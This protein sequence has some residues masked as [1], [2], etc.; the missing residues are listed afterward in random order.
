MARSTFPS[1]TGTSKGRSSLSL[2]RGR[3]VNT[4]PPDISPASKRHPEV[5]RKALKGGQYGHALDLSSTNHSAVSLTERQI[6]HYGQCSVCWNIEEKTGL[7][8]ATMLM[9]LYGCHSGD[10]GINPPPVRSVALSTLAP[11]PESREAKKAT[12]AAPL[13]PVTPTLK[14]SPP[15]DP[16]PPEPIE[17][18]PK[19]KENTTEEPDRDGETDDK[20]RS[21]T[22]PQQPE[23]TDASPA[24]VE[25]IHQ[26]DVITTQLLDTL[27]QADIMSPHIRPG[28]P[29]VSEGQRL[30]RNPWGEGAHRALNV[31]T[32]WP[33][34]D[35]SA[36]SLRAALSL[37]VNGAVT[38]PVTLP[39]NAALRFS[40]A[41]GTWTRN[42][43]PVNV[44]VLV[45]ENGT[46]RSVWSDQKEG[47][48]IYRL[49]Q[50][51]PVEISLSDTL[52]PVSIQVKVH[53]TVGAHRYQ[54]VAFIAEPVIVTR[55]IDT[56]SRLA[57]KKQTGLALAD[58]VLLITV[59][60]QRF[61]SL[62]T[63]LSEQQST[64]AL[65]SANALATSGASFTNAFSVS[66]DERSSTFGLLSSQTP[67]Y[68]GFFHTRW[69]YPKSQVQEFYRKSSTMLP[70][71]LRKHGYRTIGIGHTTHLTGTLNRSLD[72][73]FDSLLDYRRHKDADIQAFT[74]QALHWIRDHVS[75][76]W[77]MMLHYPAPP[78]SPSWKSE[79]GGQAAPLKASKI[80]EAYQK[81]L[82]GIDNQIKRVMDELDTLNLSNKTVVVLTGTHGRI[83]NSEH[84]CWNYNAELPCIYSAGLTLY[85]E[86]MHVPLIIRAPDR[87]SRQ[88]IVS[89]SVSHLDVAPTILG[90]IGAAP[91]ANQLG[92]D[93]STSLAKQEPIAPVPILL[94]GRRSHGCRWNGYKYIEHGNREVMIFNRATLYNRSKSMVELYDLVRDPDE[95]HNLALRDEQHHMLDVLRNRLN[96]IHS[97]LQARRDA[98]PV[99]GP[100]PTSSVASPQIPTDAVEQQEPKP[101]QPVAAPI[102]QDLPQEPEPPATETG[103]H[104]AEQ[105]ARWNT[106]V[107]HRGTSNGRFGGTIRTSGQW[108]DLEILGDAPTNQSH[109]KTNNTIHIETAVTNQMVGIRFRTKP[110]LAPIEFALTLDGNAIRADRLYVGS[111]GLKL[112]TD[113]LRINSA[114][115]FALAEARSNGPHHRDD[116]LP[117][118]FYWRESAPD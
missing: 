110:A 112:Y 57:A 1:I 88:S 115:Q 51:T 31:R 96:E 3:L 9:L 66:N 24:L 37:P 40:L 19:N 118:V 114:K 29:V 15:P 62:T 18:L 49:S 63:P 77:F 102:V 72:V 99:I 100:T 8:V 13:L 95:L 39:P 71:V 64:L 53:N 61:D 20:V 32:L 38:W 65:S 4:V 23:S 106:L 27:E 81:A 86:E 56:K 6:A 89:A 113:P 7:G 28:H 47:S 103:F 14:V 70:I 41:I 83:L 73:G 94:Q 59:D 78:I 50:W 22:T 74:G 109:I 107:F 52:G 45:Q 36:W 76:R 80:A 2:L 67:R 98:P 82:Q 21:E 68:G 84:D 12:K 35:P 101:P 111:Y 10:T 25:R 60:G 48:P 42:P 16:P 92:R 91:V 34:K 90:L 46:W 11:V 116:A 43:S 26:Q 108:M 44:E 87:I 117:G 105:P 97:T 58:N 5:S 54:A 75:E 55:A 30:Y 85:D 33:G 104:A 79:D 17:P 69:I 93:L